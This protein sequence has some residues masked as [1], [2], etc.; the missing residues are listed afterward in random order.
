MHFTLSKITLSAF[1]L[2]LV[3]DV[4]AQPVNNLLYSSLSIFTTSP[5]LILGLLALIFAFLWWRLKRKHQNTLETL[6]QL[7]RENGVLRKEKDEL[8]HFNAVVMHDLKSPLRT[9]SSFITLFLRKYNNQLSQ[10]GKAYLS[11]VKEGGRRMEQVID[12]I[13][14]AGKAQQFSSS[15]HIPME[16]IL[17]STLGNLKFEL[18]HSKASIYLPESLPRLQGHKGQFLQLF[19]NILA[20]SLKYTKPGVPPTITIR[21]HE[22]VSCHVFSIKD[23]GIGI[24]QHQLERIFQRHFRLHSNKTYEGSGLGLASCRQIMESM[25]GDIWMEAVLGQSA[26]VFLRFPKTGQK[27]PSRPTKTKQNKQRFSTKLRVAVF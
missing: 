27:L 17:Q 10:E 3:A 22:E 26:T 7:S 8:Q 6:S 25:K 15:E 4:S 9:M 23:N 19:Q 11:Y 12:G 2:L 16:E 14:L 20:N 5:Q 21:Y 1:L 24:P 18:Q 13:P